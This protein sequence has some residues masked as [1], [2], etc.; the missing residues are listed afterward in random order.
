MEFSL[1][2]F[3]ERSIEIHVDSFME[4]SIHIMKKF[5][6]AL[7]VS[8]LI[9]MSAFAL[10]GCGTDRRARACQGQYCQ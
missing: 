5:R 9:L 2:I 6:T 1:E 8:M 10:Y 3:V 4:R 7:A